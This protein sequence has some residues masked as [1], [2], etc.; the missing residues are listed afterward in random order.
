MI[1]PSAYSVVVQRRVGEFLED[2]VA[3]IDTPQLD[4]LSITFFN[5]FIFDTPHLSQF[6]S[7]MQKL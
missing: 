3:R 4:R 7:R 2:F 5:Q 1:P 6:I